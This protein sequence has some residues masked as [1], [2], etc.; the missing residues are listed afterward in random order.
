MQALAE[1]KHSRAQIDAPEQSSD[2]YA[3]Y[4]PDLEILGH[5]LR[6]PA[7]GFY[8]VGERVMYR[9]TSYHQTR[10]MNYVIRKDSSTSWLHDSA[11]S[12]LAS[13]SGFLRRFIRV[14]P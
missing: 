7:T 13:D 3:M 10:E 14:P 9:R 6:S 1:L 12:M 4:L 2:V 8:D 11:R 5:S